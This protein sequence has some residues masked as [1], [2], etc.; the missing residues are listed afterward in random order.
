MSQSEE[1][2]SLKEAA[3]IIGIDRS[4][5]YRWNKSGKINIYK[6]GSHTVVKLADVKR[7][8]AENET[9]TPIKKE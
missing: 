4:A 7:I 2:I 8:K 9:I 6:K 3:Q 5:F 1:Y